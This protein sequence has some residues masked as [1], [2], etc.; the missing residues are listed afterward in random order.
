[1]GLLVLGSQWLRVSQKQGY[2]DEDAQAVWFMEKNSSD[3]H[4]IAVWI[5]NNSNKQLLLWW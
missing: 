4:N 1:M 5:K 3:V 2:T